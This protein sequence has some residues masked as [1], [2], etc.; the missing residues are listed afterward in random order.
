MPGQMPETSAEYVSFR[1]LNTFENC[2]GIIS[3]SEEI[4]L[5][6]EASF[7][8]QRAEGPIRD[9]LCYAISSPPASALCDYP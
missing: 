7:M 1:V 4:I 8:C 5:R 6:A 9:I 3:E 2:S